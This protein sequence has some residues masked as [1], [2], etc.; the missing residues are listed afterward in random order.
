MG[1]IHLVIILAV[2]GVL[3]WAF[4]TY[5]TA[6]DPKMKRIIN[7]VVIAV[8]ILWLLGVFGILPTGDITIPRVKW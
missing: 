3:L 8:V 7:F 1:L 6:I 4:N 2:I 5:V